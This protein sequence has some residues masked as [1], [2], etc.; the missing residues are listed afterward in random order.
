MNDRSMIASL[1][2]RDVSLGTA[3]EFVLTMGG[4]AGAGYAFR[5]AAQQASKFLNAVW[6]GSG[7]AVSSAMAGM[8]TTA[9]GKTAIAYYIDDLSI[10]DAKGRFEELQKR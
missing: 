9:I 1:S 3:K 8:G 4:V 10:E 7:S 5:L 6:P 2:G